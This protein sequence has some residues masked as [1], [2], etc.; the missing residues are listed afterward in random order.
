MGKHGRAMAII[1]TISGYLLAIAA[2]TVTG[3]LLQTQLVLR[4]LER[5]GATIP[6]DV[7]FETALN[8][9]TGF[10]V[11][12]GMIVAI[13]L[14]VGF[15]VASGAK[16]VLKP[17]APIAYPLGGACAMAAAL[18]ALPVLLNLDG[19]TPFAGARGTLGFALQ[20][21]A[22][23]IGGLVFSLYSSRRRA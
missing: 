4:A 8:D 10:G 18:V 21:L 17:L 5:A 15:L 12:F 19:I 11:Q 22:G 16:Q 14:A 3:S 6:A 9:L 2:T 13:A 23:G 7:R 20:C 1:R